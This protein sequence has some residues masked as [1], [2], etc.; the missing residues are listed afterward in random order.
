MAPRV[1]LGVCLAVLC[2][3]AV[4][5]AFY[6]PGVAPQDFKKVRMSAS[7]MRPAGVGRSREARGCGQ[8]SRQGATREDAQARGVRGRPAHGRCILR[9]PS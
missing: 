3:S 8:G 4:A 6:L 2:F 1:A 5:Q 9:W 7:R